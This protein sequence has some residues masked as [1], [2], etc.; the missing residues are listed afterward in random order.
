MVLVVLELQIMEAVVVERLVE[1]QELL[2]AVQVVVV[3]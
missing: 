3:L 2:M 1:V